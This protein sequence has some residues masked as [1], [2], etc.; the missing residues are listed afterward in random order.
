VKSGVIERIVQ[1]LR[2]AKFGIWTIALTYVVTVLI[3]LV[4]VHAGNRF[5]LDYRDKLVGTAQKESPIMLQ[6]QHG[7]RLAAAGLDTAGN[8][9][10]GL[11]SLLAGYG[12]PAGYWVAASRGFVGGV[13]S[14]DGEH[15][16]RLGGAHE[17][18][19]YLVTLL[20]QLIPYTLS[21][22]AGVNLGLAAFANASWTGYRGPRV[23]WLQIPYE[24]LRDACWIYATCL[25]LFAIASLFEFLM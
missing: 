1:A 25:P 15:R 18:F 5:A 17:A 13:V 16:S 4:M 6:Y 19:Y 2:H 3:G 7:H 8:A 11:A 12:V 20:L 23:R 9:L 21:G 22:G 10:G 24:A 14:V